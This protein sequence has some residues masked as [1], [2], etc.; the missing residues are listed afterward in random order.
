MKELQTNF[1]NGEIKFGDKLQSLGRFEGVTDAIN[2]VSN[3]ETMITEFF[4]DQT[5]KYLEILNTKYDSS[6]RQ[7]QDFSDI[8]T[9][10]LI[11]PQLQK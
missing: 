9:L 1:M 8:M 6:K 7:D 4:N 3:F 10:P 5:Y 2:R 11:V